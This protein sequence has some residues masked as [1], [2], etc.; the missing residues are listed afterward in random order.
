VDAAALNAFKDRGRGLL[1]MNL[2][3]EPALS[4][5]PLPRRLTAE[6]TNHQQRLLDPFPANFLPLPHSPLCQV[7][8]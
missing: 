1:T 7:M 4:A 6:G 8:Y 2:D 5:E 3:N